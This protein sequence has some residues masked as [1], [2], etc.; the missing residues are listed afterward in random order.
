MAASAWRDG[1]GGASVSR[2][3]AAAGVSRATFYRHFADREDCFLTAQRELGAALVAELERSERLPVAERARHVLTVALGAAESNPA[4]ASALMLGSFAAGD[5]AR[6][7]RARLLLRIEAAIGRYLEQLRRETPQGLC[8]SP[9]CLLGGIEGVLGRRVF[10][11]EIIRLGGLLFGLLD[12]IDSY[13]VPADSS[14]PTEAEWEALGRG[15]RAGVPP[16]AEEP[17]ILLLPRGRAAVPSATVES[18]HRRRIVAAV[19]NLS[20]TKGFAGTTVADVVGAARVSRATFYRQFRNREDA[21]LAAQTV[22]LQGSISQAA[23]A[24]FGAQSWPERVWAGLEAMLG[25]VSS[26]PDLAWLDV[27]ESHVVGA[28]AIRRSIDNRMAFNLF[29][30]EGYRQ[31]TEARRLPPLCSE[32]ISGAILALLRE[33]VL[34]G[35]TEEALEIL[36]QAVYLALGP[37][38]GPETALEFVRDKVKVEEY[39]T[40]GVCLAI[41]T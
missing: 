17:P 3:V 2:V 27:V 11:G 10:G 19:A 8:L 20:R 39:K 38:L 16:S 40:N 12:W 34:A 36:P 32:A 18:E 37:F 4:A 6:A 9:L 23:G 7:E 13:A 28:A 41:P 24:F 30:E 15:F 21:I 14:V 22:G 5:A 35:R 1:Y 25:Y 33:R 26:Q 29:L 31:R